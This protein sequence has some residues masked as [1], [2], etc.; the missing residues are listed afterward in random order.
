MAGAV[1]TSDEIKARKIC[2]ELSV[3]QFSLNGPPSYRTE[4][5]PF[6]GFGN[7]GNGEKEGILLAARGMR[8]MRTFYRH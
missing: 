6:G 4:V 7:S 2:K 5:A 3:G 8:R 1:V